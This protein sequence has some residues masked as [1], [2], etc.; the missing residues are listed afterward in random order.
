MVE[1]ASHR[2]SPRSKRLAPSR[3][4]ALFFGLSIWPAIAGAQE[5]D[6]PD[7]LYRIGRYDEAGELAAEQIAE[8][9]RSERWYLLKVRSDMARGRYPEALATLEAGVGKVSGGVALYMLGRDVYRFNGRDDAAR[10]SFDSAENLA[11]LTLGRFASAAGRVLLGRLLLERGVDA[12]KILDACYDAAIKQRPDLV[13]AYLASAELALDKQDPALAASTLEK[14]PKEAIEDPRFHYLL[15]RAF[16]EDE[17]KRSEKELDEAL[18]INPNHVDS[19]L[20]LA[21]RRIDDERYDEADAILKRAFE[22]NPNEPRGWAYRAA[23]A[24]LR[25]D[26]EGEQSA[27]EAAL[28]HWATNP[29][30]DHL[31][32]RELS[33]KYRFV[34]GS[35]YQRKS[36]AIDP[37]YLPAKVQLCQDLL[38]LGEEEEGWK[39]ADEVFAADA[40]NVLAYN[41]ITLR[42]RL[43]GFRTLSGEGFLVRMDPREADL[44]GDRV[45]ALLAKARATLT[46]K[47]GVKVAEPVV[48][49]I[50]PQKKEFAV[51]TFGLPGA[52]GFLGVCFGKV[53]TANSPASQG[54]APSNWESV[55]W[56]EYCHVVTLNKT[57]NKMPRWLSEGISVYEEGA[58]DRAW[59]GSL[60]PKYRAMILGEDFTPLSR[61][62]SAFLAPKSATHLQFAYQESALAVEFLVEKAGIEA[63]KGVLDDLGAGVSINDSLAAREKSPIDQLDEEFAKFAKGKALAAAPGATFDEPELAPSADSKAIATWLESHPK[64]FPGLRRL[65][66]KLVSEGKWPEARKAIEDL[67]AAYPDYKGEDNANFLLA[68]V[69]RK[70]SDPSGE[71]AALEALAELDGNAGPAYLRL[72][73]LEEELKDWRA[74]DRDARRFLAVNPL[75]PPPFRRLAK[76]SEEL[77][78]PDEALVAYRALALIDESDPADIHFRLAKLLKQTGQPLEA[79]REV[80]KSLEEAPRFLE[81]HR[82]LL[83]LVE[84][85]KSPASPRP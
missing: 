43:A 85:D 6:D 15:A 11:Q 75:T 54:E 45:V 57:H 24:H 80:L 55:L 56:H 9:S 32:G 14:A 33:R 42:D 59:G 77:G 69:C 64:N 5:A 26:A 20:L 35:T 27:R 63:L 1:P 41:L 52:E 48:V 38:R 30:V 16:S 22:V 81:A 28:A 12:R 47:Y 76:A 8:R 25:N 37:G 44:Y 3:V 17:R 40:Y 68:T 67:R 51:R 58:A 78:R 23:L 49:E 60:G 82:L 66:S 31:I 79:R 50:F 84:P 71:R 13:E 29:E 62:S 2:A 4:A 36:L 70:T 46:E 65:A 61:L 39:L 10:A 7:D 18:K 74:M 53:I 72:M 83:E 19:L 34:E 73:E 21:D